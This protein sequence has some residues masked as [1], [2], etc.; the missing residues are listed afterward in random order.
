MD[1]A[2][3]VTSVQ[4]IIKRAGETELVKEKLNAAVRFVTESAKFPQDLYEVTYSGIEIAAGELRQSL[5]LPDR[6]RVVEYM[7]HGDTGE[8][9]ESYAPRSILR[10]QRRQNVYYQAGNILQVRLATAAES[11]NL[12][13]Y[14]YQ[15]DLVNNT[16]TNWLLTEVPD[17]IT[18]LAAVWVLIVLGDTTLVESILGLTKQDMA[19]FVSDRMSQRQGA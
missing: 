6:S 10:K 9:I 2:G 8:M 4:R 18:Q 15:S 12:G 14:R 7:Q 11:I 1:F 3:A 16:D 5:I 19:L 17:V 13:V